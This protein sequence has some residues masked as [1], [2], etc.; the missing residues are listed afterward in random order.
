MSSDE[1]TVYRYGDFPELFWDLQPDAEV[2]GENPHIIARLLEHAPPE[3]LWKL[4][5][6][7]VLLR[8][9]EKL[10]LPEHTRI[11]WSV[12]VRMMREKRGIPAPDVPREERGLTYR[13]HPRFHQRSGNPSPTPDPDVYRY[14][15]LPDLFWDMPPGQVV[16]GTNPEVIAR[17]LENGSEKVVWKIVPRDVLLREFENLE[18]QRDA[19]TFWSV[20]VDMMRK[21]HSLESGSQTAA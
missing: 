18:L 8:D 14:G 19:R 7:D 10:D 13:V 6:V 5:P 21:K 3:T 17:L 16:D 15:D 2:D 4:V 20:V 11:F 1:R 12:A 9:F